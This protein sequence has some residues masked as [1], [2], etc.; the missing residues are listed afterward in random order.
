MNRARQPF[1]I[2]SLAQECALA[3]LDEPGWIEEVIK[4]N[5]EQKQYLYKEFDKL[6]LKYLP[7]KA[8]FI[9]IDLQEDAQNVFQSLMRLGVIVRPMT[10]FGFPLAIRVSIGLPEE[11]QFFIKC[12]KEVLTSH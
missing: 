8:N 11:N 6:G 12:L 4:A 10:G 2:N 3:V 7:T 5:N 9:F 1:N